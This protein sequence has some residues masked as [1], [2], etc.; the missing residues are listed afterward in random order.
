MNFLEDC[1]MPSPEGISGNDSLTHENGVL[2]ERRDT[3][4]NDEDQLQVYMYNT[5]IKMI[6]TLVKFYFPFPRY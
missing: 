4:P 2:I 5:M 1:P 6:F 3:T